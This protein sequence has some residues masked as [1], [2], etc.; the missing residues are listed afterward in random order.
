MEES[1][2]QIYAMRVV[3]GREFKILENLHLIAKKYPQAIKAVLWKETIQGFLFVETEDLDTLKMIVKTIRD[4]KNLILTPVPLSDIEK[5]LT[6]EVEEIEILPGDI[7]EI[8]AGPFK[9]ERAKV[10]RVDKEREEATV[11][12]LSSVVPIPV[13]VSIRWL[14][15]K[16]KAARLDKIKDKEQEE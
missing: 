9:G 3:G 7:V 1:N 15:V 6:Y 8:T 11:Q 12:L 16:E 2:S 14:T 13:D 5:M 10:I 4:I